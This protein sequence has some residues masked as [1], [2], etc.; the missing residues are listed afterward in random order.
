MPLIQPRVHY[1][2]CAEPG[3]KRGSHF[4]CGCGIGAVLPN[5][6]KCGS[7]YYPP[8]V[9]FSISLRVMWL[10][11]NPLGYWLDPWDGWQRSLPL[12]VQPSLSWQEHWHRTWVMPLFY[13]LYSCKSWSLLCY[14][15][16]VRVLQPLYVNSIIVLLQVSHEAF[17]L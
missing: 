7:H 15:H 2:V 1:M 12:V 3:P 16:G 13:L 14:K 10:M 5:R 9:R 6:N 8:K 4:D 17:N 11:A